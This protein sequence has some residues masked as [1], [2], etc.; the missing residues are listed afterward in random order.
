VIALNPGPGSI[1]KQTP[2]CKSCS[3]NSRVGN[4]SRAKFFR[5][6]DDEFHIVESEYKERGNKSGTNL[7]QD[8]VIHMFMGKLKFTF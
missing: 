5:F 7:R 3:L 1:D 4:P 8:D 6:C 2:D